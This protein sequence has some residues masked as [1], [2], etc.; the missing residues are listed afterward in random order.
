MMIPTRRRV[1]RRGEGGTVSRDEELVTI[2]V[3]SVLF[4]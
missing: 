2:D 4:V 3:E 1:H